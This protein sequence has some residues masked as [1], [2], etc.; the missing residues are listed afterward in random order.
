MVQLSP[1]FPQ[2]DSY[3]KCGD[4]YVMYRCGKIAAILRKKAFLA[5]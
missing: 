4:M 2:F 3:W 5:L 1:N